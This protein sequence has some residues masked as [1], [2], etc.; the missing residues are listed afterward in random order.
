MSNKKNQI[1]QALLI[2]NQTFLLNA[3]DLLM[4]QL[5]MGGK[6][7][8]TRH[9]PP[10]EGS[11]PPPAE[12]I[13]EVGRCFA[14]MGVALWRAQQALEKD[15]E[16]E[17]VDRKMYRALEAMGEA[18]K[19]VGVEIVDRT[20]TN[21]NNGHYRDIMVVATEP[22]ADVQQE[23][24]VETLKPAVQWRHGFPHVGPE[25]VLVQAS[26][27]VTKSPLSTPPNA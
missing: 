20:G 12:R 1:P 24:I 13:T 27:V 11:F 21:L 4:L 23:I 18:L 6:P 26:E 10:P 17:A 2:Q 3:A 5:P 15:A 14:E 8:D 19:K 22:S 9:A 16:G 7:A 25:T